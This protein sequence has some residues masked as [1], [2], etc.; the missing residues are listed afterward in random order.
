M[1]CVF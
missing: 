1:T